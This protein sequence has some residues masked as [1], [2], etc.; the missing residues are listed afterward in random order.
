MASCCR[1]RESFPF[2]RCTVLWSFFDLQPLTRPHTT[3]K[4][5]RVFDYL[6]H[7]RFSCCNFYPNP[8][9]KQ[10]PR[11]VQYRRKFPCLYFSFPRFR[12]FHL[13]NLLFFWS[14]KQINHLPLLSFV[15]PL[16]ED[17]FCNNLTSV[18]LFSMSRVFSALSLSSEF[19]FINVEYLLVYFSSTS[20]SRIV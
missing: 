20:P 13:K 5:A 4:F 14:F 10:T 7:G 8:D 1:N 15:V 3:L 6:P 9:I 12:Y 16:P 11:R 19:P 2:H 18:F 17:I